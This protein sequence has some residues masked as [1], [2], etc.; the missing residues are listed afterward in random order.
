MFS[1]YLGS[2]FFVR[3]RFKDSRLS[4]NAAKFTLDGCTCAG[5]AFGSC[6]NVKGGS[7]AFRNCELKDSKTDLAKLDATY[8]NC[9]G[10][11]KAAASTAK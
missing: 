9:K 10:A 4:T 7:Y 1:A 5:T 11:P 6:R 8:E 2:M 3:C